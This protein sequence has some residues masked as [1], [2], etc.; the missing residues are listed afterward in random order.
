M[1]GLDLLRKLEESGTGKKKIEAG[2]A[3]LRDNPAGS[4]E[5]LYEALRQHAI[6]TN[7][8]GYQ[9][10]L[11]KAASIMRTGKWEPPTLQS[12]SVTDKLSR[13]LAGEKIEERPAP[14]TALPSLGERDAEDEMDRLRKENAELK[15]KSGEPTIGPKAVP[16]PAKK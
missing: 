9:G 2:A 13:E 12:M 5:E 3:F 4:D 16:Q 14:K 7:D 11:D 6:A 10:T 1:T 8:L 15:A